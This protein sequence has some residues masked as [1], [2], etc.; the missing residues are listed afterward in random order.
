MH[1]VSAFTTGMLATLATAILLQPAAAQTAPLHQH[2]EY[3]NVAS[4]P[5][6]NTTPIEVVV[7]SDFVVLPQGT[8]WLRL[9]YENASLGRGSYL[10]ITSVLDGDFM[11]MHDEHLGQ[12]SYTSCYFNGNAVLVELVAGPNTVGNLV[13]ITKVAAGDIN[14]V[15]TEPETICGG[16]DDR[17]P[18]SDARTARI[19][20]IGCTGWIID[21]PGTGTNKVHLSAGHCVASGN[22]LQFAVPSS[23]ANCSLVHPPASKQFAIDTV[24]DVSA[25]TGIGND[26]WAFRC[27]PNSTTGKTTFEEQN[28]AWTLS[29]VIPPS[30]TTLRNYG[31]GLDGTNTNGAPNSGSCSCPSTS[32][33]GT[34]N[35]TQQTHTGP[36]T[37]ISG[38]RINHQFDTCGGNSGS[39]FSDNTTG[40]AIGIHTNGGCTSTSG[41]N[42]G[43]SI[44]NA[45]LQAAIVTVGGGAAQANDE[46]T[47]AIT[48]VD[49]TNGPFDN[50]GATLSTSVFTCG[51]N[52]GNDVWF[53]YTAQLSGNHVVNTCTP[54]RTFDTVIQVFSGTCGA[55][56]LVA[57]NDDSCGLGSSLNVALTGGT[58]YYVRCGGYNRS[59]GNFDIVVD[60]PFDVIYDAGPIV[61]DP[62]DGFGGA[63]V[64]VLAAP[65]TFFGYGAQNGSGNS[66]ADDFATNGIWSVN[67]IE[68][69]CY[70]TTAVAP[71][72]TGV[73]LEIYNGNPSTGGVPIVGS[74]GF[75]T[76][77]VGAAGYG[78]FNGFD[79]VYRV[80]PT[81][82]TDTTR[83]IQKVVVSFPAALSLN[84]ASI[85]GGR[86]YLRYAFT[87]SV[88]S[89]PWVPPITI[90]GSPAT[91]SGALQNVAGPWNPLVDGTVPQGL[92]FRLI[93]SS[94]SPGPL[95]TN[96]GGGCTAATLDVRGALHVGGV[97]HVEMSGTA[98]SATPVVLLG[99]TDPAFSFLPA[100]SCVQH[101]SLEVVHV[102][103]AYTWQVPMVPS[104][105]GFEC[106]TQGVQVE[107]PGSTLPCDLGLGWRFGLTDGYKIRF[108]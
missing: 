101:A 12:W 38:N 27:F 9:H 70:Q 67:A 46:C 52:V 56:A 69:Y 43:T 60:P 99:V 107:I 10:R 83:R 68:L 1:T 84:S 49:G 4:G 36:L 82:L 105:V 25:N 53:R 50:V 24:T 57:C 41:S 91:G 23:N 18:S 13:E 35:Q 5:R 29:P 59:S 102:G 45:G 20:P 66:V 61:T 97:V 11:T 42:S 86:Y 31:Y 72:I 80:L 89:G 19:N 30:G 76:N 15:L 87:G 98:P 48:I 8:P 95:V 51:T 64:S 73:F 90:V 17:T 100:C 108:W 6:D 103:S 93:G 2:W 47:G 32:T 65:L 92:P 7:W 81:T 55:L 74:P 63:A 88:A 96:L 77:L 37:S 26:W 14:P 22:V 44:L 104:A 16:T 94:G 21:T 106:Y 39:P 71:S 54:T 34:R 62:D 40:L 33:T 85:A 28:A 78:V 79:N 75:A 58:T 3:V